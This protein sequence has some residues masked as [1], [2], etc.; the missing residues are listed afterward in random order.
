MRSGSLDINTS[1]VLLFT[2][3]GE[4]ANRLMHPS[5]EI[6][7]EY[8]V[9]ILGEVDDQML[10][11][12]K[13]G[14]ELEDG[15]AKFDSIEDAGGQGSNH[16]YHVTLKEGRNQEVRRLWTSQ[17]VTVSRLIR[18]RFGDLLLPRDLRIGKFVDVD[19]RRQTWLKA[20]SAT[21]QRGAEFDLEVTAPSSIA[22]AQRQI[23][24]E[25]S[26]ALS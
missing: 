2:N 7:R 14:V 24:S 10:K 20:L 8:A 23:T 13:H 11:N 18:V 21:G 9:R 5:S 1:G 16:W 19:L 15:P 6:E 26:A 4:L 3:S 25:T 22:R 17:G 12:L